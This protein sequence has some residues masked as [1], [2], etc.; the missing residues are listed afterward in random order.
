M[1]K[2]R[3]APD[4]SI[5]LPFLA[6]AAILV[7][8]LMV[9]VVLS[10]S[11]PVARVAID[12]ADGVGQAVAVQTRSPAKAQQKI[13]NSNIR[14][15]ELRERQ[16]TVI[17]QAFVGIIQDINGQPL[18]GVQVQ[19][20]GGDLMLMTTN[21]RGEFYLTPEAALSPMLFLSKAGY[22]PETVHLGSPPNAK[23]LEPWRRVITMT[24]I[25]R[26]YAVDGH[27][28]TERGHVPYATRAHLSSR[29]NRARYSAV[30]D[31]KGYYRFPAVE[32]GD[33]YQLRVGATRYIKSVE[34]GP[35]EIIGPT[36]LQDVRLEALR[37]ADLSIQLLDATGYPVASRDV[38]VDI[39]SDRSLTKRATTDYAGMFT[40]KD[41]PE[42]NLTVATAGYPKLE[43]SDI[44]FEA[45]QNTALVLTLGVGNRTL[46]GRVVNEAAQPVVGAVV[47]VS[48]SESTGETT[49]RF[50]F[51][52]HTDRNGEF[53]FSQLTQGKHELSVKSLSYGELTIKA[54]PEE[55]PVTLVLSASEA[56]K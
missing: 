51:R 32:A 14:Q 55:S 4:S 41:V 17:N 3:R 45:W 10:K 40:L 13:T 52:V 35:L 18:S 8:L 56:M 33:D 22:R 42:G 49:S 38:V 9:A 16:P 47:E 6:G 11:T 34:Q 23:E 37:R 53:R 25:G 44:Q 28:V 1:R 7:V 5:S 48:G 46:R 24:A 2:A 29:S 21:E 15:P 36:T 31:D 19:S 54:A 27:V 20:S 43:V 50:T 26:T 30:V 39:E 12:D